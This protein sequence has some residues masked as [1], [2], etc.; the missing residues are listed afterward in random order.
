MKGGFGCWL[1][2]VLAMVSP[3]IVS[4]GVETVQVNAS[5]LGV[6]FCYEAQNMAADSEEAYGF[7]DEAGGRGGLLA[8]K[9]WVNANT[10]PG[11]ITLEDTANARSYRLS[12]KGGGGIWGPNS[13][14]SAPAGK[15]LASYL[16]NDST[17]TLSGLPPS[18]Y[19]VAIIFSGDGGKY[20]AV[21]VN[22]VSKTYNEAG[23]L[24]EGTTA[25]G[26][27]GQPS[28]ETKTLSATGTASAG[29]V[30]F[31]P[32]LTTSTLTLQTANDAAS[33]PQVRGT[34]AAIQIYVKE[35][36]YECFRVDATT[37]GA[38]TVKLSE[39]LEG[40]Q[41]PMAVVTLA[42]G[43]TLQVDSALSLSTLQVIAE[44]S[45]T[46]AGT[47]T[48]LGD[49][50]RVDMQ[51]VTGKATLA[52]EN[53]SE[54]PNVP[55]LFGVDVLR[56]QGAKLYVPTS[57]A[58]LNG[59]QFIAEAGETT[60]NFN[61]QS[62]VA[63][64][65]AP[66]T[67]TGQGSLLRIEANQNYDRAPS[68][69][70]LRAEKG[71]TLALKGVN[72]FSTSAPPSVQVDAA[73]LRAECIAG[74]HIKVGRVTLAND[75]NVEIA[76]EGSAYSEEGLILLTA[77]E[78]TA[79]LSVVSG[80]SAIRYAEGARENMVTFSEGGSFEVA[81]DAKLSVDVKLG[82]D[83]IK[84]GAGELTLPASRMRSAEVR[85]GTLVVENLSGTFAPSLSGEG[86]VRLCT[87]GDTA[88]T[89][90][91]AP[92]VSLVFEGAHTFALGL[93][94]P[95]IA[96]LPEG[97]KLRLTVS[98]DELLEGKVLLPLG[99][100]V[101]PA[102]LGLELMDAD[103]QSLGF[104]TPSVGAD[105]TL[106][107]AITNRMPTIAA[108]A[109]W[110]T[111]DAWSTGSV[112]LEGTVGLRGG[113][114]EEQ[115]IT[116]TLDTAIPEGIAHILIF[117]HVRFVTSG[118]QAVI[119]AEVELQ[120]GA[121]LTVSSDFEAAFTV[122]EGTTLA[123]TGASVSQAVTVNG[124]LQ[125]DG[126]TMSQAVTVNGTLTSAGDSAAQNEGNVFAGV[127]DVLSGSLSLNAAEQKLCGTLNVRAGATF[128]NLRSADALY[129]TGAATVNVW[130]TVDMGATRWTIGSRN[131]LNLYAGAQVLG[132]GQGDN[133][134][135]S[136]WDWFEASTVHFP[137]D[138]GREGTVSFPAT[139][140]LRGVT[141]TFDVANPNLSVELSG[142]IID[143][144][145]NLGALTKAGSGNSRLIL[146]GEGKAYA[147]A[148]AVNKGYLDIVG[149][150][151]LATSS[152]TAASGTA[153]TFQADEA[154]TAAT[155][156]VPITLT[157]SGRLDKFG[158]HE[159]TLSGVISGEGPLNVKAGTLKL[160]AANTRSASARTTVDAGATLD[161]SD[162]SA[163]LYGMTFGGL[164]GQTTFTV[165]GRLRTRN[166]SYSGGEGTGCALGA[167]RS[168]EY[169]VELDGGTVTFVDAAG[170][171]RLGSR[172]F[173]VTAAGATLEIPEGL[174]L[175][176]PASETAYVSL[177]AAGTMNVQGGGLSLLQ[178]QPLAGSL[179]IAEGARLSGAGTVQGSVTFAEGAELATTEGLL[180]VGGLSLPT[181]KA[182]VKVIVPEATEGAD[183]LKCSPALEEGFDGTAFA[184]E[185][186]PL[187]VV[188]NADGSAL[189]LAFVVT[190]PE[191]IGA[192]GG[193]LTETAAAKL[194]EAAKVLGVAEVSEVTGRTANRALTADEISGALECF[195][196]TGLVSKG[197][198]GA[199]GMPLS[200]AYD[201]GIARMMARALSIEGGASE[202]YVMLA[203]QVKGAEDGAAVDYAENTKVEILLG[204]VP[205]AAERL[206]VAPDGEAIPSGVRWFRF[207][208]APQ[209][210]TSP[211]ISV[212]AVSTP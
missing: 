44:G 171:G 58:A 127:V 193:S 198:P 167:L 144:S 34:V 97:A 85:A 65:E 165:R 147:G 11:D 180:T 13:T 154:G 50:Q 128:K 96:S 174:T 26:V 86:T 166:W 125:L 139:L 93:S 178:T 101:D 14:A 203:V 67:V 38:S 56:K 126:A 148:T 35:G 79:K 99:E 94:R 73:T 98:A 84:E 122:P 211:G 51:Q 184:V 129:Y 41:A 40:T 107:I 24:V 183:V 61:L 70:V 199:E 189:A 134:G 161:V 175:S 82:R 181:T 208:Y 109:S 45:V 173:R 113:E 63:T 36:S 20:S 115:A 110:G 68:N 160:L 3:C 190:L 146:S 158:T 28:V 140:R 133:Y 69:A 81:E 207:P 30:M 17:L 156:S 12:Y 103:G 202:P 150:T 209:G 164:Q 90:A 170:D 5:T 66:M 71:A 118:A 191:T 74:S 152:I 201:F 39:L 149:E 104:G 60:L 23:E 119:P 62:T 92:T 32:G 157:G 83:I 151:S 80:T 27:R 168:N 162:A 194:A 10:K 88:F 116:V 200:V 187:R 47:E 55:L 19:D 131:V 15:L 195:T 169:A 18:G 212:R 145:D 77:G 111:A 159:V 6:N 112:P 121:A 87:T 153:L 188:P 53:V 72:L 132:S 49:I 108:T 206:E 138:G 176:L 42:D 46:V 136:A 114:T 120:E 48:T 4:A 64:A 33:T 123:L 37:A 179:R 57:N 2:A 54:A 197:E 130:G 16:D 91:L 186:S 185:G 210:T 75:A 204:G 59:R 142:K 7:H 172:G 102:K 95:L 1:V 137:E 100:G 43:A 76:G 135:T 9:L 141:V 31:L 117:G 52:Y 205:V 25:W 155:Y 8:E 182:S 163:R 22:G 78:A 124:T 105:G 29:Q 21:T 192:D 177:A 143:G 89:G 106:E 196:G